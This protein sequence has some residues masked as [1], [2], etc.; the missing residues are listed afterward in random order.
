MFFQKSTQYYTEQ[1]DIMLIR[2]E[3]SE[4]QEG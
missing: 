1:H 3:E 2:Q 4:R